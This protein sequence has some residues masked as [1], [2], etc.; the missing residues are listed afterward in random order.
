MLQGDKAAWQRLVTTITEVRPRADNSYPVGDALL[1]LR[2]DPSITLYL[3][4]V[5][6]PRSPSMP[7]NPRSVSAYG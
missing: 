5:A 4:P 3:S 2:R 1:N 7:S 6:K